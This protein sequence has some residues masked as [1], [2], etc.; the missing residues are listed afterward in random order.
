MGTVGTLY[1]ALSLDT[2]VIPAWIVW[3]LAFLVGMLLGALWAFRYGRKKF[4]Y[5]NLPQLFCAQESGMLG[6]PLFMILFGADQAYR[7]GVLDLAQ[8]VVA[9]PVIALLSAD[10]G[11]NPNVTLIKTPEELEKEDG[12][13]TN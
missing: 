13:G 9:Y 4:P 6:I 2:T 5:H 12:Y 10:T 3:I 11:E 1:V 7:M 8:A